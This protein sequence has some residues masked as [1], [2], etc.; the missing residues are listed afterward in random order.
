MNT[1]VVVAGSGVAGLSAIQTLVKEGAD[2][3]LITKEPYRTYR[4]TMLPALIAGEV[5][6]DKFF[7]I[8]EDYYEKNNITRI[9]ESVVAIDPEKKIVRTDS[10]EVPYDKLILALGSSSFVPETKLVGQS[11][12]SVTGDNYTNF[13]G[14]G[15]L[16]DYRDALILMEKLPTMK[17]AV[18]IGGGLLGLEAAWKLREKGVHVSIIEFAPRLL[19]RQLDSVSSELLKKQAID[20]D[21]D[22]HLGDTADE[23]IYENGVLTKVKTKNGV[24]IPAD[25]VLFSVGVRPNVSFIKDAGIEVNRGVIVDTFLKT[26]KDD[27]YAAGDTAEFGGTYFG[28]WPFAMNSGKIAAMNAIGKETPMPPQTL[29]TLYSGLGV[30]IFSVGM[31]NFDDP[32]YEAITTGSDVTKYQKLFFED[33]HLVG[34]ILLGDTGRSMELQ[35]AVVEKREKSQ[36]M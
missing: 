19:P 31:I 14:I 33:D 35:K 24:E 5:T 1:K 12:A 23:I 22:L 4:R 3:T 15:T 9:E 7:M 13:D 32:K 28:I 16:R 34:A 29:S 6:E 2:I 26:T 20:H 25:F 18:V 21:I 30:R 17:N 11:E 10:K 8:T 36:V 27:I